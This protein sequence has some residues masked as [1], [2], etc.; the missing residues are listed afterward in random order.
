MGYRPQLYWQKGEDSEFIGESNNLVPLFWT[1]IFLENPYKIAY[2]E[3]L[4]YPVLTVSHLDLIIPEVLFTGEVKSCWQDFSSI[5]VKEA[6]Q[7][8]DL[9]LVIIRV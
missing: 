6:I 9:V 8:K 7:E 2:K 3:E 4:Y 5:I 1:L